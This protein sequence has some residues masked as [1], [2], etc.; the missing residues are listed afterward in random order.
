[1]PFVFGGL[2]GILLGTYITKEL[3]KGG[4]SP[5]SSEE[6]FKI[7]RDILQKEEQQEKNDL[8]SGTSSYD[9]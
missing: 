9:T 5:K 2:A 1:M 7:D 4:S 3:Y 6:Y 8:K